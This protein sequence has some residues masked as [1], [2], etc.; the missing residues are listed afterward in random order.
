MSNADDPTPVGYRTEYLTFKQAVT[1][2][3]GNAQD[4]SQTQEPQTVMKDQESTSVDKA[5]AF[6][7]QKPG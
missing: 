3:G 7:A 5:D 2:V 4:Y 1:T 6:S